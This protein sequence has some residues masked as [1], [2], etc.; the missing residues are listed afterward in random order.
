MSLPIH[1]ECPGAGFFLCS[2]FIAPPYLL[3]LG[4]SFLISYGYLVQAVPFVNALQC[5]TGKVG[6]NYSNNEALMTFKHRTE[7]TC[8]RTVSFKAPY[9]LTKAGNESI[10]LY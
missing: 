3:L 8:I 7:G 2:R 5:L 1:H 9:T 10:A 4:H 6:D